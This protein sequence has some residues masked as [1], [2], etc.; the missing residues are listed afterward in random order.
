MTVNI[1]TGRH[2]VMIQDMEEAV[3]IEQYFKDLGLLHNGNYM[4]QHASKLKYPTT[5]M[6]RDGRWCYHRGLPGGEEL[7]RAKDFA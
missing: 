3:R 5:I 4:R 1:K 6:I 2:R 7:H